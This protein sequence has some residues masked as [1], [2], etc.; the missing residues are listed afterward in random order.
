M[1]PALLVLVV[2]TIVVFRPLRARSK[3]VNRAAKLQ[4]KPASSASSAHLPMAPVPTVVQLRASPLANLPPKRDLGFTFSAKVGPGYRPGDLILKGPADTYGCLH[5]A[6]HAVAHALRGDT[7]LSVHYWGEPRIDP[8][9]NLTVAQGGITIWRPRERE[10]ACGGFVRILGPDEFLSRFG[11][12]PGSFACHV[13]LPPD[14]AQCVHHA[15]TYLAAIYAGSAATEFFMP[16]HHDPNA[17]VFDDQNVVRWFEDLPWLIP[18][19]AEL[20]DRAKISASRIVR[21]ESKAIT[22][23]AMMLAFTEGPVDGKEA[24]RIIADN[25]VSESLPE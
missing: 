25:L 21:R 3:Y 5:E 24:E 4:R 8:E 14:C 6:G 19:K 13:L 23:L 20:I 9:L 7:L 2:L 12:R 17:S 10:C 1:I 18:K 11:R 16:Q 22:A 15:V